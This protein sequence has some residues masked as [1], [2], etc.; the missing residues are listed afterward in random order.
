MTKEEQQLRLIEQQKLYQDNLSIWEGTEFLALKAK[1]EQAKI[2]Y[3]KLIEEARSRSVKQIIS[4]GQ[5][6]NVFPFEVEQHGFKRNG[7]VIP[8]IIIHNDCYI[9][10]FDAQ[11]RLILKENI[12]EFLSI[13]AYFSLYY[14]TDSTVE[15]IYGD[16]NGIYRYQIFYLSEDG[17][18]IENKAYALRSKIHETYHYENDLIVGSERHHVEFAKEPISDN[19]YRYDYLYDKQR[20][21]SQIFLFYAFGGKEIV[22]STQKVNFK[23]LEQRILL[24]IKD[25]LTKFLLEHKD[26]QFTRLGIDCNSPDYLCIC[27]DDSVDDNILYS[28][29]DWEYVELTTID[30]VDFPLDDAQNE[31]LLVCISKVLLNLLSLEEF[32][33]LFE[34]PNFKVVFQDH[35]GEVKESYPSVRKILSNEMYC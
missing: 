15:Y 27:M 29:A 4:K 35:Q 31:K 6:Y 23:K 26:K 20:K 14:Y 25:S 11:D 7:K 2:D 32:K 12:S 21:L 19:V 30:L 17:K 13:P 5:I 28:L 8:E 9:H 18:F 34:T 10:H 16:N 1:F 22:Y 3:L 24:E 33:H